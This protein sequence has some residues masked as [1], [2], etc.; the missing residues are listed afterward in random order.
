MSK[1][2]PQRVFTQ[3]NQIAYSISVKYGFMLQL[4]FPDARK[5]TD[6]EMHGK[7][8]LSVIVDPKRKRF[9][10]PRD[11]I[12]DKAKEF[13]G[14]VETKDAYMYEGKEGL[15]VFLKNGRLDILPGS[16]HLWCPIDDDVRKFVD[17]LLI[18]CYGIKPA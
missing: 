15:K 3:L 1:S 2:N 12:K 8:N 17:W 14:Y 5:I 10:I 4:H 16:L 6:V 11:S 7:E 18:Y 9:P 13:L